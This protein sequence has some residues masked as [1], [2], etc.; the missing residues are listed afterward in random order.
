MN[1]NLG[2]FKVIEL[3]GFTEGMQPIFHIPNSL[4]YL[5]WYAVQKYKYSILPVVIEA[6]LS[7]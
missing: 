4:L 1:S 3:S 5:L 7:D 2:L 6:N